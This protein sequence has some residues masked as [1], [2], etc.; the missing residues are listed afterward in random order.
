ETRDMSVLVLKVVNTNAPGLKISAG[1]G[2]NIWTTR[3][4]IKLVG[5]KVSDPGGYDIAHVIGGFY[6]LPVIDETG[7]TDAYDLD[8]KWN[9]NLRGTALQKEIERVTRE[10]FGLEVVKDNRPVEMLV[11]QK[12]N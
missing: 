5:Y 7:L 10:Q 3:D 12:S 6:N 11:V 2:P 8:A 1:G 4:S 9:G